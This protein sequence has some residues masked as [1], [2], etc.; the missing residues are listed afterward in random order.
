[1]SHLAA[2]FLVGWL[3]LLLTVQAFD[4]SYGSNLQLLEEISPDLSLRLKTEQLHTDQ[5]QGRA[6]FRCTSPD[7]L[8]I[9]GP[10]ADRQA[11]VDTD[12]AL[13][14]DARQVPAVPCPWLDGLYINSGHGSRGLITTPLAAEVLAAWLDDEPLPVPR[15]VAEAC[16]PNRFVMRNLIRGPKMQ[17]KG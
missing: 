10:L 16:H 8:P 3:A 6:A 12:A 11:F 4:L 5:L 1:M 17:A 9:D 2:A 7:Y 13:S 14:R 15:G